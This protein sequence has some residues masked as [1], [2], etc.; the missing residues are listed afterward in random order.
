MAVSENELELLETYLDE[1]LPAG[2]AE[3][4]RQRLVVESELAGAAAELRSQRALRAAVWSS[5]EPTDT[6]SEQMAWRIRGAMTDQHS[7]LSSWWTA[8][9]GSVAAACI[10]LGFFAGWMGRGGSA[11]PAG[12]VSQNTAPAVAVNQ[13]NNVAMPALAVPFRVPVTNEYGQVVDWQQFPD[14][15]QAKTFMENLRTAPGAAVVAPQN[16]QVKLVSEEKF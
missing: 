13:N 1:A 15:E 2:E 6:A 5:L 14:A 7:G 4:L 16:D 8:R 3:A 12:T 11:G 9:V 10:V